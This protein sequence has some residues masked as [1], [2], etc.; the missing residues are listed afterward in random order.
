MAT[1][2]EEIYTSN[3]SNKVKKEIAKLVKQQDYKTLNTLLRRNPI[4]KNFDSR[5]LNEDI[6]Q[7]TKRFSKVKGNLRLKSK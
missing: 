3:D 7:E 2:Y 5:T 6:P 1:K 4:C